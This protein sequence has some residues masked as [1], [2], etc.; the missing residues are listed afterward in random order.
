[1]YALNLAE[2]ARWREL[3]TPAYRFW[4]RNWIDSLHMGT[5]VHWAMSP[6]SVPT[7]ALLW[8]FFSRQAPQYTKR[9]R[10]ALKAMAR[11]RQAPAFYSGDMPEFTAD[12]ACWSD[13]FARQRDTRDTIRRDVVE[14]HLTHLRDSTDH[15]LIHAAMTILS[16]C[17][18]VE[19]FS[20]DRLFRGICKGALDAQRLRT[21]SVDENL[22]FALESYRAPVAQEYIA[23]TKLVPIMPGP[24]SRT[25][26]HKWSNL[27]FGTVDEVPTTAG[28]AVLIGDDL[29]LF[30]VTRRASHSIA[31]L[32]RREAHKVLAL[33]LQRHPELSV[34]VLPPRSHF[35]LAIPGSA[36]KYHD[37]SFR[38]AELDIQE[39]GDDSGAILFRKA[40]QDLFD[41]PEESIRNLMVAAELRWRRHT[42]G[43]TDDVLANAY[44]W[45]L[46]TKLGQDF[47]AH[48]AR[49]RSLGRD[50]RV[51]RGSVLRAMA[52]WPW[53]AGQGFAT[54]L[55]TL[56]TLREPDDHLILYRLREL[57]HWYPGD[58]GRNELFG[59]RNTRREINDLLI[60]SRGVRNSATHFER[61]SDQLHGVML[62][63]ARVVFEAFAAAWT[64]DSV[65]A[66]P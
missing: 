9:Q 42:R 43:E 64:R 19:G 46:R 51:P 56:S 63:L 45:S 8:A 17:L 52:D 13:F 41:E 34:F 2:Y 24:F 1:M 57:M 33:R 4:L 25:F 32:H 59:L 12:E 36:E 23:Y 60:L 5:R 66:R 28:L 30:I 62:Y 10:V 27:T 3:S 39:R 14:W 29:D 55:D 50:A 49:V 38:R 18:V 31:D 47:S 58:L 6:I 26:R 21:T 37:V 53:E 22:V 61:S 20:T 54:L 16:S 11:R 35:R 40:T 48:L 7:L 65:E 44:R 15:S